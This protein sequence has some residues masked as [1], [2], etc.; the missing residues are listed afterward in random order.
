MRGP[1][2]PSGPRSRPSGSVAGRRHERG[3]GPP[4]VL[5]RRPAGIGRLPPWSESV[6]AGPRIRAKDT[7]HLGLGPELTKRGGAIGLGRVGIDVDPEDVL[8]AGRSGRPR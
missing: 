1:D 8:P 5:A 4:L 2:R 7:D 3:A 6:L